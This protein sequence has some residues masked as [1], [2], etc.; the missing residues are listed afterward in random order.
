MLAGLRSRNVA[1]RVS[2]P[3][4]VNACAALTTG[5]PLQS[6][7][8]GRPSG[9][10]PGPTALSA[11]LAGRLHVRHASSGGGGGGGLPLTSAS[12]SV[13]SESHSI[14]VGA[15]APA[16]STA[17][18]GLALM[19]ASEGYMARLLQRVPKADT[20]KLKSVLE[21]LVAAA[22][23][24]RPPVRPDQLQ[25]DD[26]LRAMLFAADAHRRGAGDAFIA[27]DHIISA[28]TQD[29]TLSRAY[30]DAGIDRK[31]LLDAVKE[32]R[33]GGKRVASEED[34]AASGGGAGESLKKYADNLLDRA[35]AGKLDPV[36]GRDEEMR[37][38]IQVLSRRTKCNPILVGPGEWV[39]QEQER[40][41][42]ALY[43]APGVTSLSA[44]IIFASPLRLALSPCTF[45]R[46][47]SSAFYC[48]F[49]VASALCRRRRQDRN[50]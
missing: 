49:S 37:R 44:L 40:L 12:Q 35:R 38:V 39:P 18:L 28:S 10:R 25:V 31:A 14:A 46:H 50:R 30:D 26:A 5:L 24:A 4:R 3:F 6:Q 42:M 22:P 48:C 43:N 15:S 16:I 29:S 33:A 34:D 23:R 32:G 21:R 9:G 36:I 27:V 11:A 45:A 17:H 8:I 13:L 20:A 19:T 7:A 2:N 47:G 41:S 1:I